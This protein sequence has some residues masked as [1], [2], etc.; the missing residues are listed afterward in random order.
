MSNVI[1]NPHQKERLIPH[2]GYIRACVEGPNVK[3]WVLAKPSRSTGLY[4]GTK[5]EPPI[6]GRIRNLATL[7]WNMDLIFCIHVRK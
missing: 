7:I 3:S 2:S 1:C 6:S 5:V 4:K